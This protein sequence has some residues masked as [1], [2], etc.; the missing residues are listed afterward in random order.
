MI[1]PFERLSDLYRLVAPPDVVLIGEEYG[2]EQN[3]FS[4]DVRESLAEAFRKALTEKR[5]AVR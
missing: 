3:V 5:L 1:V 4:F 2:Q